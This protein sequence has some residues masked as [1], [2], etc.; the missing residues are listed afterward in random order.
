MVSNADQ[1]RLW[2]REEEMQSLPA[3]ALSLSEEEIRSAC[4]TQEVIF[5]MTSSFYSLYG[6][7]PRKKKY[8]GSPHPWSPT[9][10]P[11]N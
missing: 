6:K 9:G 10:G 7:E 5:C 4:C 1:Y 8:K 3:G 2:G 11:G